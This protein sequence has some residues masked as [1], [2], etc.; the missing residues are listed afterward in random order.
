MKC[1]TKKIVTLILTL[2]LVSFFTFL[3][4]QVV[5]GDSAT[6]LLGTSA[7][8]ETIEALRE[9]MGLN[10]P[11]VLR[12]ILWVADIFHGDFGISTQYK[13]EVLEL[14]SERLPI[15]LWLSFIA[16]LMILIISLPLGIFIAKARGGVL[17]RILTFLLHIFMAI[18]PFFLGILITLFFGFLLK[19]F[20]PGGYATPE[21]DFRRFLLYLL[22]PALAIAIPKI[23]MVITF[24]KNSI[25]GELKLDYIKTAKSKGN[26]S[27]RIL[28]V[29]VLKNA[30]IPVI[31]FLAMIIVDVLSGSIIIEQVFAIPGM[32]RLLVTA[33]SN[34]DYPVVQMIILYIAATVV[35]INFLVDV[36]YQWIDPRV[37]V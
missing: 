29:H 24:L 28:F 11:V 6:A 32:G 23:A 20:T 5:S 18:P 34:R 3:A 21:E 22:F 30:M 16:I 15:T 33:I 17:D 10:E 4:F 19:W 27:T 9:E 37:K 25:V 1:F 35:L 14:L 8:P 12:Y 31:T 2:F 36:L 13:M 26:G 7:T